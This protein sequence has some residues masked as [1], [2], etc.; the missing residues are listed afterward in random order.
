VT[1]SD[2]I[3]YDGKYYHKVP[4]QA[5]AALYHSIQEDPEIASFLGVTA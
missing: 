2:I 5:M 4:L 1:E 3:Y